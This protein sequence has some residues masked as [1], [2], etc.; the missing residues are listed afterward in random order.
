V[1][2]IVEAVNQLPMRRVIVLPNNSNILMAAQQAAKAAAKGERRRQ[3]TVLPTRTA[4]QGVA[5][6]TAYAPSITDIDELTAQ[7]NAQV[8]AVHTGEITQAVR[9]ATVDGIEVKQGDV[10]GLHDGRLVSRGASVTEVA[11]DLLHKMN[12]SD[13]AL[14]TIYYGDFVAEAAAQDFAE[15]VRREY[16]EQDIELA[17]G[18]QPHYHYI[19][20]IE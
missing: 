6:L 10:I 12:A 9:S 19:L 11:L 2:E 5:A 20:S 13:A 7:M 14:I 3:I 15:I 17:Y 8:E 1:A 4:P 16:P 18:G